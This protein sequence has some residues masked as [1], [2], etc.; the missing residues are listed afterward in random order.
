[1]E[2]SRRSTFIYG[3]LL[4]AWVLVVGWQ[5]EEHLSVREAAKTDLRNRSKEVANT[6]SAVIRGMR[7]RGG[8]F[9]ERLEPVLNELVNSRTNELLRSTELISI[10]LINSSGE[11]VVAA[12][13]PVDFNQRDILQEGEH[14]GRN[15]VTFVNPIAG[16]NLET[17]RSFLVPPPPR[18]FTNAPRNDFRRDF[19]RI[20]QSSFEITATNADGSIVTNQVVILTNQINRADRGG[21]D[22]MPGPPPDFESGP[23]V[24]NR[25]NAPQE[26]R[27]P[28]EVRGRMRRPPWMRGMDEKE[29][30]TLISR[31]ELHGLVLAMST[32]NLQAVSLHDLWLRVIIAFFAAISAVG[33]GLAWRNI[34]KTSELQIRLVRASELNTHLREMNLAAAGLAHET[35]N[36][37]NIIR[38][39]AQMISKLPDASMDVRDKS[40][41]IVAETDKVAAQLNEF[42]NYSR[43]REVRRN[44][45]ALTPAINEITRALGYDIEE[46]RVKI[47]VK[48]DAL[49]IEA[50]EQLLRQMLF[51]LLLNA[52]QAVPEGGMIQLVVE[53]RNASEAWLEVRDNGPGVPAQQRKE[54]FK[55][56]FT[57]HQKGTGL[58]LAVVQ[59]IVLAHGWEIECLANEPQGAIFRITHLKV[60]A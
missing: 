1:M 49:T 44:A 15:S 25:T 47:E 12:G 42:I 24:A 32:G 53:R 5:V 13:R 57:T 54:I 14:W 36:P 34:A 35:R 8:L 55:P 27:P 40:R 21:E 39:Q 17:N 2:I 52:I 18:E 23:S 11:P 31:R 37:L 50:D 58:G 26:N 3:L 33:V 28:P 41:A 43:P 45:I 56:Y 29:F 9:Q 51:N 59:Q 48:G 16:A 46:K 6:L 60:A 30:E 38:G 10:V 7:F 20:G 19:H 22:Q 4:A